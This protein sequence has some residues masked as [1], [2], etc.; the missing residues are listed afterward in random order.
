MW[1]WLV[2]TVLVACVG[3]PQGPRV[4]ISV[5]DES[6]QLPAYLDAVRAWEPLGFEVTWGAFGE[7]PECQRRWYATGDVDCQVTLELVREPMLVERRGTAAL[8]DISVRGI[9]IDTRV[10]GVDLL[11]AMAHESGH[12]LLDTQDHTQGGIMGGSTWQMQSVDYDLA[13]RT[14]GRGC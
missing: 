9:A 4:A 13:C 8:S 6:E 7:L 12:I 2:L 1:R 3:E 11:V 5:V 14:I 10:G